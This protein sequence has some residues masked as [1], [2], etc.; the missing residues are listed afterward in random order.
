MYLLGKLHNLGAWSTISF[1]VAI[2]HTNP[3]AAGK[4]K[5]VQDPTSSSDNETSNE[6]P[7]KKPRVASSASVMHVQ[8]LRDN[9]A[10]DHNV[11]LSML[12]GGHGVFMTQAEPQDDGWYD[13]DDD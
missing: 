6:R 4:G 10:D 9:D 12:T 1:Q 2:K 13:S 5:K 3:F 8:P 11:M 7:S